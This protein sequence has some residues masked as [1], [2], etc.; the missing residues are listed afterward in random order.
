MVA[1]YFFFDFNDLQKQEF[2]NMLRSVIS[3]LCLHH[4]GVPTK[5]NFLY[6][7]C[8]FQRRRPSKVE[9]YEALQALLLE[10]PVTYI[11]VDALDECRDW[12]NSLELLQNLRTEVESLH[13]LVTSRPEREIEVTI[14]SFVAL[15]DFVCLQSTLVEKD[16]LEYINHRWDH[17]TQ[18]RRWSG[19]AEIQKE[20][21]V[22]LMQKAQGM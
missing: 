12:K 10:F 14:S 13:I 19:D 18:F 22:S 6:E 20:V 21:E 5:L 11:I 2:E 7:T 15:Q 9:M 8:T 16:I 17:D 4:V 3:Q 1:A